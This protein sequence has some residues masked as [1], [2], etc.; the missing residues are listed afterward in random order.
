MVTSRHDCSPQKLIAVLLLCFQLGLVQATP[1]S[2]TE[3]LTYKEL[4][5]LYD[6]ENPSAQVQFK[7][8]TLLTT[9]FVNNEASSRG[10]RPLKPPGTGAGRNLRVAQW[11]IERGLEYEALESVFADPSKFVSL[12]D[13]SKYPSGS[14]KRA[15]VLEQAALL[16]GADIIVLN[17]VDWGMKRTGY[18][19][20]VADLAAALKMNYA[21]GTE[22]IE[23][24]PIALG[25]ESFDGMGDADKAA[26]ADQ[27]TIDA[28]RYKGLHGTAILS[29]F[30]LVNVRL[31]PFRFQ[32]HDWYAGE[33]KGV[34]KV[35]KGKRKVGELAFQEKVERE[36]R[37]GGRMMLL[38][39]IED[40]D[41]P[42]G[43][44]TIVATHLESKTKP[45]SRVKQL[46]EL[47]ATIKGIEHPVVVAGDMNTSARD[48]TP[49][50]IKR[51]IKKRF[52]SK[53]FW[54]EQSLKFL[55]GFS[56]PNSLLLGGLN[57][58]R[59]QADPTVRSIHFVASNP[60]A[61][62][63]EVLKKFRFADGG[64]FDFRGERGRS[65]GSGN[66]PLANSNQRGGKGF[67]TTFEVERT[68]GFIGKY[69]LDWIFVKPPALKS[70][71][72]E[73]Q[74]HV[75]APHFGRTLKELN[76]SIEDRISDHDPLIVDLPLTPLKNRE[77]MLTELR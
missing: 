46:E 72:G 66:S 64:A 39:D 23:I 52:G 75:F 3:L 36:V 49:T 15:L 17:E 69:K 56:W 48:A 16:R 5:E 1:R 50:S 44:L 19:N 10:A 28:A 73:G 54:V 31:I 45:K 43:R 18:R 12:L 68:L 63:F 25:T 38:A 33:K 53:K 37:R 42:N 59:K 40:R 7:L 61:K 65:I 4:V 67:I 2:S 14:A 26:L 27:I 21:F 24:D 55:T 22:F 13:H 62:F 74:S 51:E 58:Y 71:Y 35:E 9:P 41:I 29:R 76:H 20:V 47:L 60:E 6:R 11:N 8:Q 77:A 34:T 32:G 30:P 70:P 57:E